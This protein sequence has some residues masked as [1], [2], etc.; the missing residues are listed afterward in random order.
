MNANRLGT[1]PF[2]AALPFRFRFGDSVSSPGSDL[3]LPGDDR[4]QLGNPALQFVT[5]NHDHPR[6][7]QLD[8]SRQSR[9]DW[10]NSY[11]PAWERG[12]RAD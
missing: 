6:S 8:Q 7:Q 4:F 11:A 3:R 1:I 2:V 5:I 10:F 12:K 9:Q